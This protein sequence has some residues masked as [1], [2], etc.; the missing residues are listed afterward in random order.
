MGLRHILDMRGQ[1]RE[2]SSF[3]A[4][5]LELTVIAFVALENIQEQSV[6]GGKMTG[7][8]DFTS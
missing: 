7:N 6:L 3:E 4:Q 2:G 1:G 5:H 8:T